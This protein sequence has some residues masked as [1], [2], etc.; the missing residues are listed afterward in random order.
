LLLT[1]ILKQS[2]Q[3]SVLFAVWFEKFTCCRSSTVCMGGLGIGCWAENDYHQ[4][5]ILSSRFEVSCLY[6][7]CIW[8]CFCV[9][10]GYVVCKWCKV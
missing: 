4:R 10:V 1:A 8:L 7:V 5:W 2:R 6:G 9:A 3:T